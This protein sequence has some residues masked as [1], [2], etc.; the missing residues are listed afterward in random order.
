MGK[1]LVPII[2]FIIVAA[3]FAL[4]PRPERIIETHFQN[5]QF[6]TRLTLARTDNPV[7]ILGD[8]IVEAST[9]PRSVCDHPIVNAGVSG[10]TTG[11]NLGQMLTNALD[12]KKAALVVVSLGTNDAA[13]KE[14][15]RSSPVAIAPCCGRSPRSP[16]K[17]PHWP[18]LRLKAK[19]IDRHRSRGRSIPTTAFCPGS[20]TTPAQLSSSC[21]RCRAATPS[22]ACISMPMAMMSGTRP[23]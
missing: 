9:L 20:Q 18:S 4:W 14:A 13:E 10:A 17:S 1:T 16:G 22:M 8:S 19:R 2:A 15:R 23:F 3:G 5:R 6:V 7:V 11:S 21:L 12:G